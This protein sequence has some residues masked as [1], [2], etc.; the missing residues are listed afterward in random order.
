MHG[1]ASAQAERARR[2]T[3]HGAGREL[4][5]TCD[6]ALYRDKTVAV[7]GGGDSAIEEAMFLTKFAKK[8]YIIHRR[9]KLRAV[10]VVQQRAFDNTKIEFVW[11]TVVHEIQ[12]AERVENIVLFNRKTEKPFDLAVDGVFIYVGILPNNH[13]VESRIELD[14]AGFVLT[15]ETMHTNIPGIFAA[16]DIIH[17]VLRQVVTA[18]ADGAT[19]AFSAERWIQENLGKFTF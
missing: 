7:I 4:L 1:R 3:P 18:V 2:G 6:G 14:T 16:G 13:L 17:K 5:P 10:Q 11:D 12:G 19:A 8:V 15:D 9:D